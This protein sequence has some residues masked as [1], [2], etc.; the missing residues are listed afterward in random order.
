MRLR[1]R[2]SSRLGTTDS[3]L[4]SFSVSRLS[5]S[6]FRS[7]QNSR[8]IQVLERSLVPLSGRIFLVVV[9]GTRPVTMALV[10]RASTK[11][12]VLQVR[13]LL[14]HLVLHAQMMTEK[15]EMEM[16]MMMMMMNDLSD[17]MQLAT[18]LC[19]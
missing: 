3:L 15:A 10:V 16:M 7:R 5:S 19:A 8:H 2:S 1:L 4:S 14:A 17:Q 12:L 11:V 13:V 6:R 9:P 18:P